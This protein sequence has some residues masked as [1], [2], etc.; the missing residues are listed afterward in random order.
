V[1]ISFRACLVSTLLVA[2]LP[3]WAGRPLATDDAATA[4]ARSC[5]LESWL[6]RSDGIRSLTL[7]P[8]CGLAPGLEL[9]ADYT[10]SR[11]REEAPVTAGLA[12]KWAPSSWS[13]TTAAGEL[14][15]GLKLGAGFDRPAAEGWQRSS[16]GLLGLASWKPQAQW[17]VHANLG[18]A[19][20]RASATTGSLFNLALV[21]TPIEQGLLFAETQANNRRDVFGGTAYGLGGRWWLLKDRLGLDLTTGRTQGAGSSWTVGVGWY[22]LGF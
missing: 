19:R 18:L 9:G 21:W 16:V 4:D 13:T 7:A 10:H 8:A 2:A 6:G 12:L 15:F 11:P 20:D 3:A 22:G 14:A 17:A 1:N 5:Q